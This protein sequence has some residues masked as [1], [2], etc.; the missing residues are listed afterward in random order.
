M[1]AERLKKLFQKLKGGEA[2][3]AQA[4]ALL[5]TWDY[6]LEADSAPAALFEVWWAKHLKPTLL[7]ALVPNASARSLI[8]PG[9]VESILRALEAPGP[10]FGS[11]PVEGRNRLLLS[12]LAAAYRDCAERMGGKPSAWRWGKIHHGFFEHAVSAVGGKAGGP[13]FNVGPLPK[14]GGDSTP[15]MAAYRPMDFRVTL[16]ASVRIVIDVGDWD[17]SKWINSPGQS[18]DPRSPHYGDLAPLW[19]KGKYVPMLYSK[20]AVDEATEQR[21]VLSPRSR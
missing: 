5:A 6:R 9:D 17:K 18:G 19:A 2:E 15:M 8:V 10:G 1:P 16:G 21:I 13:S 11:K 20:A 7:A 4:L 12:T 3:A 14:G